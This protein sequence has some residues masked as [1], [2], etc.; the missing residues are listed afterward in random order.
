M[1]RPRGNDSTAAS[2]TTTAE[3]ASRTRTAIAVRRL[4]APCQRRD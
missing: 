1:T 4:M 2:T 3:A